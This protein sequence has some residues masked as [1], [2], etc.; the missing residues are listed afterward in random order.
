[1]V[2]GSVIPIFSRTNAMVVKAPQVKR[3]R[4]LKFFHQVFP[5]T[6]SLSSLAFIPVSV[7]DLMISWTESK[8]GSYWTRRAWDIR[9]TWKDSSPFRLFIFFSIRDTSSSQSMPSIWRT[10]DLVL[11]S[12]STLC[13]AFSIISTSA[14]RLIVF[15]FPTT[16]N[17][18]VTMLYSAD[19]TPWTL[20]TSSWRLAAQFGQSMP[21]TLIFKIFF[22]SA[23]V[24]KFFSFRLP[25]VLL[26]M[27]KLFF[28]LPLCQTHL[29]S[30]CHFPVH[31]HLRM[32]HT[33][34]KRGEALDHLH[35]NAR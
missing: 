27:S 30:H 8:P 13:P 31:S 12:P 25:N 26:N 19:S 34:Y 3:E 33:K 14:G 4:I 17:C 29:D 28:I 22:S 18:E 35:L 23:R 9:S 10:A 6:F 1:M 15:P 16:F 5:F 24:S 20:F 7:M 11:S 32:S 2:L 21:G